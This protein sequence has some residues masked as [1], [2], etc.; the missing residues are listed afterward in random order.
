MPMVGTG[1]SPVIWRASGSIVP[2]ITM[3][4]A[5]AAA[6]ALASSTMLAASF[7]PRPSER[8]PPAVFTDCGSRPTWPST[9]MPRSTRKRIV[10]AIST[11]PSSLTPEQPTS[12]IT[13]AELRNALSLDSW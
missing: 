3:A 4:K 7:S 12:F 11:P 2:S 13:R 1:T 8:K 6:T 5:P 10:S 9:G